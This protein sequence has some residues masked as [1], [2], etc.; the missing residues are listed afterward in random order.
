M[1]GEGRERRA[2]GERERRGR[3]DGGGRGRIKAGDAEE[4]VWREVIPLLIAA[5]LSAL[6]RVDPSAHSFELPHVYASRRVSLCKL[7]PRS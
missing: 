1:E 4:T 3:G 6:P 2:G 7:T 5:S